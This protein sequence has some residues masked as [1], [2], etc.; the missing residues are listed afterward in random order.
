MDVFVTS[1]DIYFKFRKRIQKKFIIFTIK[2]SEIDFYNFVQQN[3]KQSKVLK[4]NS[5][6]KVSKIFKDIDFINYG[7][8]I[9]S[10]DSV[11]RLIY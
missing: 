7:Y 6:Y 9:K 10:L 1:D 4:Q 2:G 8:F 5:E 3:I 11:Y